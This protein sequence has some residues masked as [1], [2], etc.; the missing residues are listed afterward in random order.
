MRVAALGA[1][2]ERVDVGF[3]DAEVDRVDANGHAL[4]VES[5]PRG[6]VTD[7]QA[8]AALNRE[9]IALVFDFSTL[10]VAPADTDV[11]FSGVVQQ[12]VV[13][14]QACQ[15]EGADPVVVAA[16]GFF[17]R[18]LRCAGLA[19]R[20]LVF[21]VAY[22]ACFFKFWQA[23]RDFP[24]SALQLFAFVGVATACFPQC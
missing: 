4:P 5:R 6:E 10:F 17:G 22:D 13:G 21:V 20:A 16:Q 12:R 1:Q 19:E 23:R 2:A 14:K 7:G 11:E 18:P 9:G 8:G 15:F 3:V 24:E